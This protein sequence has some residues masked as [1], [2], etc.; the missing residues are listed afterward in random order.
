MAYQNLKGTTNKTFKIGPRGVM[1]KTVAIRN[2]VSEVSKE[3]VEYIKRLAVQE[4]PNSDTRL[5]AYKDEM[6]AFIRSD[7]ILRISHDSVGGI[8]ITLRSGEI[9]SLGS[10]G[11]G[12]VKGPDSSTPDAIVLFNG[13]SGKQI[14]DSG[15]KISETILDS[16]ANNV[17][18]IGAVIGY[19]G[20]VSTPLKMRLQGK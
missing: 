1:L 18:T 3:T 6:D 16:E 12:D 4:S 5:V 2:E 14:K 11:K 10:T 20:E 15:S 9:I 8:T 17:P 13:D 19:I 7:D